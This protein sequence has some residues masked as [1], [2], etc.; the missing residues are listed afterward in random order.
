MAVDG[1]GTAE[2][3]AP[4]CRTQKVDRENLWVGLLAR[5]VTTHIWIVGGFTFPGSCRVVL[6][7][8][9]C[10]RSQWRDRA[11]LSPVFPFMP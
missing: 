6:F 5:K 11:G 2:T 10:P 4:F 8:A 1:G 9:A 3:R 7:E